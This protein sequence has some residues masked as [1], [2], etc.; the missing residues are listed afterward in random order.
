MNKKKI[1]IIS[2]SIIGAALLIM[3]AGIFLYIKKPWRAPNPDTEWVDPLPMDTML[4]AE[5]VAI[6]REDAIKF[7]EDAHPFFVDGSDQSEYS[8]AKET[9]INATQTEMS[10]RD[11]M[12]ATSRYYCFFNDGHTNLW[13][14]ESEYLDIAAYVEGDKYYYM[15][16]G[17]NYSEVYI[18]S[19]DNIPVLSINEAIDALRPAENEM[20]RLCNRI[21]LFGAKGALEVAG[22][23]VTKEQIEVSLSD[24]TSFYTSFKEATGGHTYEDTNTIGLDGD[25]VVVD[26]NMCDYDEAMKKI[27]EQLKEY[28]NNGYDKVIIDVRNN[29]GGSSKACTALLEAMDMRAPSYGIFV[30]YSE[31]AKAQRPYA[32]SFGSAYTGAPSLDGKGNDKVKLAV[33]CDRK[34]FSSATMMLV[35]VRD[36]KLGTIIGEPSANKPSC[37]GDILNNVL[38]NS[39]I[40]STVSHKKFVRPDADNNEDML[41]PDIETSPDLAYETAFEFVHK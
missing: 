19:I 31:E 13:W 37:Y 27:C 10:V 21:D 39:H 40:I 17:E 14:S 6:D 41:V 29:P 36:G 23:D 34:T 7:I 16:D 11:F 22:V 15:A 25:V 32:L 18:T 1:R 12:V 28:I 5:A 20:G 30:R 2:A 35:Y 24:G 26:F 38:E 3:F 33:L 4:S 8:K 9:Y